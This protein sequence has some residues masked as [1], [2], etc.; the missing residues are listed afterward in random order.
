MRVLQL[1]H[2]PAAAVQRASCTSPLLVPRRS[3]SPAQLAT[4]RASRPRVWCRRAQHVA[5]SA[6]DHLLVARALLD[7]VALS[8][9][10]SR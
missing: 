7:G 5:T 9:L 6:A 8:A 1:G 10:W 4:A 3:H 2:A